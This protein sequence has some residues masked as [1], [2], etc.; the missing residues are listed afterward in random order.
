MFVLVTDGGGRIREGGDSP[1]R[2]D[3]LNTR[4]HHID[5]AVAIDGVGESLRLLHA[6]AILDGELELRSRAGL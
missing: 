4:G 1:L 5:I 6:L 3:N 2:G